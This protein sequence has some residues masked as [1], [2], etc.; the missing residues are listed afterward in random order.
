MIN[1]CE[2]TL[3]Y[4]GFANVVLSQVRRRFA[5]DER[6]ENV[7]IDKRLLNN[8]T[9][10]DTLNFK[11]KS[12]N[13]MPMIRMGDLYAMYV[14]GYTVENIVDS[15][16]DTYNRCS[17]MTVSD[18]EMMTEML[19]NPEEASKLIECRLVNRDANRERL[20]KCMFREL[21]EFALSYYLKVASSD[22]G[23]YSTMVTKDMADKWCFAEDELYECAMMNM[24]IP[25]NFVFKRINGMF[26]LTNK[27]NLNGATVII[28]DEVK[29]KVGKYVEGDYYVLPSSIHELIIV[30]KKSTPDVAKLVIAVRNINR[31][32]YIKNDDF[33]SDNVYEYSVFDRKVRKVSEC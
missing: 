17:C 23:Y 25:D 24:N 4:E 3:S 18:L 21:G 12:N 33:L 7:C 13:C 20:E 14:E 2:G 10:T 31:S 15:I 16:S 27:D 28:S 22:G 9:E 32:G 8:D 26:I 6:L 19:E 30:P 5:D 29:E 11:S 1:N